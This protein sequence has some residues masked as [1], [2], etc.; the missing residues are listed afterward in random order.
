[1]TDAEN[2]SND[3]PELSEKLSELEILGQSLQDA[4][5][6]EKDVYNQLLR[7]AAEFENYRKRSE[8]RLLESHRSGKEDVL[9]QIL[10]LADTVVHA[11]ES[12][13]EAKDV[14]SLKKGFSLVAQQFEKFLKEQGLAPIKTK[15][16]KLDPLQH[17]A[18]ASE[19]NNALEDGTIIEEIQTGYTLS[20]KVIRP[21]R[22]R[23]SH[24]PKEVAQPS[25]ISQE[26]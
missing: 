5:E 4:K 2:I 21:A 17:E 12:I 14:D 23:V 1:M 25:K 7:L 10:S 11:R 22:V 26:E 13:K 3:R 9:A 24:K 18:V 8:A 16:K 6:K 15:G 19:E 20:G